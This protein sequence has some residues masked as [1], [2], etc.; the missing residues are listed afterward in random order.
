MKCGKKFIHALSI[1]NISNISNLS[2][3]ISKK[4]HNFRKR[5]KTYQYLGFSAF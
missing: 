5:H 2:I 3:Y 4:A 1:S